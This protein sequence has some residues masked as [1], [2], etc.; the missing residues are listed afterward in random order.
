M[1]TITLVSEGVQIP[2]GI[3]S[4]EA[5]RH[6]ARSDSFPQR[7]RFTWIAGELRVDLSMEQLFFHNL[8][9]TQFTAV[10]AA[11]VEEL[12]IGYLCSDGMRFSHPGADLSVEPD[13]FFLS[14]DTMRGGT[15]KEV[16]DAAGVGVIEL[17][18]APDMVLE[19]VSPSSV[20]QDTEELRERYW[21]AGVTEYWLVD[22]RGDQLRFDIFKRNKNGYGAVKPQPK[23][24]RSQVFKRFFRLTRQTDPLGKPRF[25]LIA[26]A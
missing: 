12:D 22:V 19:I 2:P 18:G 7:G 5:F 16:P 10:L 17:E 21:Q 1:G 26:T 8:V 14:Y 11:L 4:L 20:K 13:A 9:K 23:G 25:R 15:V 3:D 6:W 24:L